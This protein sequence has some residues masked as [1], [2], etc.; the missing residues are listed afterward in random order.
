M[1]I[2]TAKISLDDLDKLRSS[3]KDGEKA[4]EKVM[5]LDTSISEFL[6]Y[7]SRTN[8][9]EQIASNYNKVERERILK[10]TGTGW[11]LVRK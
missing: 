6:E 3:S 5:E 11:R 1:V 8:D 9:I 10:L 4:L 7:L 2:G